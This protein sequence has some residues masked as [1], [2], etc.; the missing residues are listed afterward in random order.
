MK[1]VT[2]VIR[3]SFAVCEEIREEQR[4]T[5]AEEAP[6]GARA[7]LLDPAG[8]SGGGKGFTGIVGAK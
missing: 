8:T 5:Q 7:D 6:R 4:L 2:S 1:Q 3:D